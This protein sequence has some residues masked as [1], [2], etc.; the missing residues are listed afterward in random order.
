MLT[1]QASFSGS[2]S[3]Y[4]NTHVMLSKLLQAE[5]AKAIEMDS[6]PESSSTDPDKRP[7]S[8]KR[9]KSV[10]WVDEEVPGTDLAT[11][12]YIPPIPRMGPDIRDWKRTYMISEGLPHSII[13]ILMT[14]IILHDDEE[15][16]LEHA[17]YTAARL[18]D[19]PGDYLIRTLES[20]LKNVS[21]DDQRVLFD[22]LGWDFTCSSCGL[23]WP[24]TEFLA[25]SFVLLDEEGK[26]VLRSG[27]CGICSSSCAAQV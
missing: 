12:S 1:C 25:A 26:A 3:F 19:R 24:A 7:A 16:T 21:V 11:T 6:H 22:Y 23:Q 14:K 20:N 5:K 15:C 13:P 8:G 10:R 18:Y 4:L 2:H 9:R 17:C 27:P